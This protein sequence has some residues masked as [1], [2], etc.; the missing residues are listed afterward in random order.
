[1]AIADWESD[2]GSERAIR[3]LGALDGAFDLLRRFPGIGHP[4]ASVTIRGV[5]AWPVGRYIVLFTAT[6]DILYIVRV[7]PAASDLRRLRQSP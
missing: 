5:S 6:D 1:M 3:I 2:F 7:V 4:H